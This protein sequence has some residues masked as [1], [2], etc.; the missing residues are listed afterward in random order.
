MPRTTNGA[1]AA[2]QILYM[3]PR[4]ALAIIAA[5]LFCLVLAV[6][7]FQPS[8]RVVGLAGVVVF[9]LLYVGESRRPGGFRSRSRL[10]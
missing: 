9:T 3:R 7:P 8:T 1:T 6:F 4:I 2:G 5:G 10:G